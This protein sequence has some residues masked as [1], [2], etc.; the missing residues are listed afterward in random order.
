MNETKNKEQD[1]EHVQAETSCNPPEKP[2]IKPWAI[3]Y[4]VIGFPSY[5]G[6]A[7][8]V[9]EDVRNA[10][11]ALKA[12]SAHN[13][14]PTAIAIKEVAEITFARKNNRLILENYIKVFE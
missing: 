5:E 9:A 6:M 12:E 3:S 7:V 8:V 4:K 1:C 2:A 10:I 11:I 13:G 14:N